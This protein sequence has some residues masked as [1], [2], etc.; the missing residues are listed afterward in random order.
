MWLVALALACNDESGAEATGAA[1]T[2]PTTLPNL[3]LSGAPGETT[4]EAGSESQGSTTGAEATTEGA[5]TTGGGGPKFD[6]G[7]DTG[8]GT[9]SGPDDALC[10][11]APKLDLIYVLSDD[12]ELW[13][14]DPLGNSFELVGPLGC[15]T[16]DGTFSMGV[17]RDGFAWIQT[18]IPQGPSNYVGDLFRLDVTNPQIASTR[19]MCPAPTGGSTSAWRSCRRAPTTR[20]TRCTA[21]TGTARRGCGRRGPGPASSG[22]STRSPCR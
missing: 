6:L 14:Y 13:T 7:D 5:V 19:T 4:T 20:A 22:C 10:P 3:T 8:P 16:T 18:T 12:R 9:T 2:Y 11:C 1:G 17:G 15:P 21:S